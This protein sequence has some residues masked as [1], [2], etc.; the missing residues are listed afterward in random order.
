MQNLSKSL[1]NLRVDDYSKV[2]LNII[3]YSVALR[4][5]KFWQTVSLLLCLLLLFLFVV[6]HVK[7]NYKL[8]Y[9]FLFHVSLFLA[10]FFF[11]LIFFVVMLLAV[12][13]L[14]F[15]DLLLEI[16]NKHKTCAI[17]RSQLFFSFIN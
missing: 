9:S 17:S 8:E 4:T 6:N 2:T 7:I 15:I 5:N 13:G 11:F 3:K 16:P 1:Y 10:H 12:L 14:L